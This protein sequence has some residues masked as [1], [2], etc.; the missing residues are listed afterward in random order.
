MTTFNP[1]I[2]SFQD[3]V[4]FMSISKNHEQDFSV[5]MEDDANWPLPSRLE[6]HI[7][8]IRR[9]ELA[10]EE[11]KRVVN[12]IINAALSVWEYLANYKINPRTGGTHPFVCLPELAYIGDYPKIELSEI[13]ENLWLKAPRAVDYTDYGF[14]QLLR[15][16]KE[17]VPICNNQVERIYQRHFKLYK[18]DAL[19]ILLRRGDKAR[20]REMFIER[21]SEFPD[22]DPLCMDHLIFHGLPI[23]DATVWL[24]QGLNGTPGHVNVREHALKRWQGVIERRPK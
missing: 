12:T 19:E 7:R 21:V 23:E 20:A 16:M 1:L 18:F 3:W 17:L 2:A 9:S 11:R 10:I 15:G 6:N 13:V 14:G 5:D 24:H 4:T 22:V 8:T